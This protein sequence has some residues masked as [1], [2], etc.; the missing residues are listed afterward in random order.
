MKQVTIIG[1]MGSNPKFTKATKD[2]KARAFVRVAI[3][4]PYNPNASKEDRDDDVEWIGVT[5]FG[6]LA[7]NVNASLGKGDH[8][9]IVGQLN[10]RSRNVWVEDDDGELVERTL[11]QITVNARSIGPAMTFQT[12][13]VERVKKPSNKRLD[14]EPADDEEEE[15]TKPKPRARKA[16][17]APRK[18]RTTAKAAASSGASDDDE[19]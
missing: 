3:D 2:K 17:T 8:V 11:D 10:V 4:P 5:A 19:F 13:D 16:K 6:Q 15:E 12:A 9:I 7:E 14:D 1:N 18:T